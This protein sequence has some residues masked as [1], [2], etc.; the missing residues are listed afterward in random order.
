M[1][2]MDVIGLVSHKKKQLELTVDVATYA[3]SVYIVNELVGS[4]KL[5]EN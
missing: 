4:H 1:S 3:T 2:K 5:F